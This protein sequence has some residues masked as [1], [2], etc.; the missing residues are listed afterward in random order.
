MAARLSLDMDGETLGTFFAELQFED[1]A[2]STK[3]RK[4]NAA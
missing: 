2:A 4:Q 1:A 3:R